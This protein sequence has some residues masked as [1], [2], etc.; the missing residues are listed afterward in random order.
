M[1]KSLAR[2]QA[3][4]LGFAPENVLTMAAPSRTAKPEFYEQLLARAQALPG[5]EAASVGSTAPLLG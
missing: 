2:L 5:V 1:I 4:D 3:L